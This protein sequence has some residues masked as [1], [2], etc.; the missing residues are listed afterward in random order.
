MQQRLFEVKSSL[1]LIVHFNCTPADKLVNATDCKKRKKLKSCYS[2]PTDEANDPAK[3]ETA[4]DEKRRQG[5]QHWQSDYGLLSSQKVSP[6]TVTLKPS[7][8]SPTC[9][10][11]TV[12]S[13]TTT[14]KHQATNERS[15]TILSRLPT[16]EAIDSVICIAYMHLF[17]WLLVVAAGLLEHGVSLSLSITNEY[18]KHHAAIVEDL[19]IQFA[20]I[21]SGMLI[22][23]QNTIAILPTYYRPTHN[24]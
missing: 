11:T 4:A 24:F 6:T 14:A 7:M 15:P 9:T 20:E 10:D 17:S 22:L 2:H 3:L 8:T 1:E 13:K 12:H 23:T 21:I 5:N 16:C 18:I 19:P